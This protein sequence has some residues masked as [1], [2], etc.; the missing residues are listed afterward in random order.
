MT[1]FYLPCQSCKKA[2]YNIRGLCAECAPKLHAQ[3][4]TLDAYY[5]RAFAAFK[6]KTGKDCLED[7]YAFE[8][9]METEYTQAVCE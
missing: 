6:E 2:A 9:F 1:D 7:W 4:R 5:G 3:H 8:S